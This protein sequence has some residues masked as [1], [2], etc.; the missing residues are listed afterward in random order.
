[1][2]SIVSVAGIATISSVHA[3]ESSDSE[4]K[5]KVLATEGFVRGGL[6]TKASHSD[7]ATAVNA[8]VPISQK[9]VAD[10][11][12]SLGA[13]GKVPA[14]QLPTI[15]NGSDYLPVAGGTMTGAIAMGS[16][17]ITSLGAPTDTTDAATKEY[18]DNAIMST[19][20]AGGA[21]S[22]STLKS[23]NWEV[24]HWGTAWSVYNGSHKVNGVAACLTTT[25]KNGSVPSESTYGLNCWCRVDSVDNIYVLG[26]WVF[27]FPYDTHAECL[28][29]CS[30]N[31]SYC[32][33]Y[34]TNVSCTRDALF[35]AP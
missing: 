6:A 3:E 13:D 11:V 14:E 29:Y 10:G 26:A 8:L 33:R 7:I 9:G 35:S 5:L 18:V 25:T 1:M 32:I 19:P 27:S 22:W 4:P 28:A 30:F 2:M 15:P 31:C 34:G 21:P 24:P 12:A 17:K 23:Q 16:A 20:G